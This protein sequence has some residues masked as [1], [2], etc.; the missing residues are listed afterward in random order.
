MPSVRVKRHVYSSLGYQSRA[1]PSEGSPRPRSL[2]NL[3]KWPLLEG[4]PSPLPNESPT[5]RPPPIATTMSRRTGSRVQDHLIPLLGQ[6]RARARAM[7]LS[8]RY[9]QSPRPSGDS[10]VVMLEGENVDV[11]VPGDDEPGRIDSTLS[12]SS[13]NDPEHSGRDHHHDDIVEH[14][15]VIGVFPSSSYNPRVAHQNISRPSS[16]HCK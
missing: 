6:E 5:I 2:A 7:S 9:H 8:Q 16:G 1:G 4:P 3:F 15:D 11:Q 12:F 13:Y 10:A 14:L